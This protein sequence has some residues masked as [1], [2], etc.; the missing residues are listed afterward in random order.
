MNTASFYDPKTG[1]LT[2]QTYTGPLVELNTPA[3][4]HAIEGIHDHTTRR[5]ALASG[6]LVEW[7]QP[8]DAERLAAQVRADRDRRLAACD[9]VTLRAIESGEQ[10]GAEWIAYRS[11]L[12]DI[13]KQDGFPDRVEWP[14]LPASL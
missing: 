12:R 6:L 1:I 13:T 2:G 10:L 14:E 11:A 5:V 4:L 9:W 7:T 3:G 8:A